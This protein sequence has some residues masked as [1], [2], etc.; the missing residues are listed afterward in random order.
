MAMITIGTTDLP[1]PVEYSVTRQ[2]LDSENTGRS[3]TG[4]LQRVR[5]R[6]GIYTVK[7]TWRVTKTQLK[8]ITDAIAAASFSAT[9][10]DPTTSSSPTKTMY[11]GNRESKLIKFKTGDESNSLWELSVELIEY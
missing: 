6:A 9:F 4:V 7:P 2:D 11:A 1:A 8:I 3:E 10:F 5:V